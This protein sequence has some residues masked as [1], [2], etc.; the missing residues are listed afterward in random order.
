MGILCA[1]LAFLLSEPREMV[2]LVHGMGR[3]PRSM[4]PLEDAF[5]IA[6]YDVLNFGYPSREAPLADHGAALAKRLAQEDARLEVTRIH[7]VGHS[8]GNLVIRW[9]L[10]N[11]RPTKIGRVVM[12]APPN[13]G[14]RLADMA[15]PWLTWLSRP[16]PDLTTH[17]ESPTH[18]L[19]TP[20]GVEIGIIAASRDHFLRREDTC[21]EGQ[22]DH[23]V[24]PASH[25]FIMRKQRVIDLAGRFL[26]TGSFGPQEK[27]WRCPPPAEQPSASSSTPS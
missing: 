11:Q 25:T 3:T 24:I 20:P 21:L 4:R 9:V 15:A 18:T 6:G 12:L 19:A 27:P 8:L 2:V 7:L 17:P 1:S 26:R 16:L 22:T 13:Q 14:A 23:I 10:A 5:K